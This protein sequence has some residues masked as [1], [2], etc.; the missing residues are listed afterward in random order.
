[1]LN[2]STRY[3]LAAIQALIAWE[4][5]ASGL[6]KLFAGTFP[7][8]L[9]DTLNDGIKGNP[10]GW[11]VSLLQS[12]VLPHS[13]L[14]GYFIEWTELAMG[15]LFIAGII[16]LLRG[17]I[18]SGE[19]RHGLAV[20]FYTVIIAVALLCAFLCVN[21]HFWAGHGFMPGL[22]GSPSDEGIDLDALIPPL[23]L[24]IAFAHYVL[25]LQLRGRT[26]PAK[27]IAWL[28]RSE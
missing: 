2:R 27:S 28:M 11:Y 13:V 10:N 7:Q 5:L 14:F 17:Q 23:S 26:W 19:P 22:N 4:W 20:S 3:L 15:L 6:N 24:I 12:V 18:M 8:T 9:G 25:I 21:F 1:M 16:L